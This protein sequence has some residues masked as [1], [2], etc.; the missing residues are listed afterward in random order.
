MSETPCQKNGQSRGLRRE[1][2]DL[3]SK[4]YVRVYFV[5]C[6]SFFNANIL[7]IIFHLG[8]YFYVSNVSTVSNVANKSNVA[9]V[10]NISN[11]S[12]ISIIYL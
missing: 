3:T 9:N 5:K 12:N 8:Y 1:V 4:E 10:S 11:I 7:L 6:D 2:T